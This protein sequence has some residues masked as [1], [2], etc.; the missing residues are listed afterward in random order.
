[1]ITNLFFFDNEFIKIQIFIILS[2][3][4]NHIFKYVVR[5]VISFSE[6]PLDFCALS[7]TCQLVS[8]KPVTHIFPVNCLVD[9]SFVDLNL[10]K[11]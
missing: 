5:F 6:C 3:L 7:L 10:Y 4:K 1:M 2:I 9:D 11:N 8:F